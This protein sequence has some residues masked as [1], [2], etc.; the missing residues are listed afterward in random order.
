MLTF[1][2]LWIFALLPLPW[3]LRVILPARK[4]GDLAVRVPFGERLR[5]AVAGGGGVT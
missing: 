3:L 4:V 5:N 2:H 1:T